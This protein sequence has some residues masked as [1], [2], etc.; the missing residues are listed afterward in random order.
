MS[1]RVH[2]R[3]SV[4]DYPRPPRVEHSDRRVRIEFGGRLILDTKDAVRVLE[5]SHPPT[6]YLPIAAFAPGVLVDGEGSS[7]CEWKGIARYHDL[8][9]PARTE[10]AIGWSYD[11]PTSGY[12]ELIGRVAIYPERVDAAWLDDERVQGQPGGFYGGWVTSE[13]DGPFKGAPGTAGW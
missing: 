8:V 10:R 6:F 4:W 7:F 3:E 9:T 13:L 5:T 11:R 2:P 1:A 12:A